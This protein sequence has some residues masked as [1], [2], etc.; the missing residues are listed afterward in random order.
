MPVGG[1]DPGAKRPAHKPD[2]RS[3]AVHGPFEARNVRDREVAVEHR[4]G[5]GL[6]PLSGVGLS[7]GVG[8]AL[9]HDRVRE[10]RLELRA[11]L[12]IARLEHD[13]C[14]EAEDST[15]AEVVLPPD[16]P[17]GFELGA[18]SL[19]GHDARCRRPAGAI[20]QLTDRLDRL[21]HADHGA[22]PL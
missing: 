8:N 10:E 19:H 11:A 18:A 9:C 5:A 12:G 16:D 13:E 22:E 4:A 2:R 7:L 3:R 17:P 6:G 15:G 20:C 21:P 14:A 1:G